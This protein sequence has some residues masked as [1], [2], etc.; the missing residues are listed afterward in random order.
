MTGEHSKPMLHTH[1]T[2]GTCQQSIADAYT[3]RHSAWHAMCS[4]TNEFKLVIVEALVCQDL[5]QICHDLAGAILVCL[6]HV[7]IPQVQN[8]LARGLYTRL[9]A[10]E[11]KIVPDIFRMQVQQDSL[12][13]A[14][15]AAG[16]N[17]TQIGVQ[18]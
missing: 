16:K 6:W 4:L 8:K 3:Q 17:R 11:N 5:L 18:P 14:H 12:C 9:L 13:C 7:E 10:A 1:V 15:V 2:V